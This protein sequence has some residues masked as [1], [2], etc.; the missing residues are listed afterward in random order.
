MLVYAH[1]LKNGGHFW[2]GLIYWACRLGRPGSLGRKKSP[3]LRQFQKLADPKNSACP[4]IQEFPWYNQNSFHKRSK[5]RSCLFEEIEEE[6]RKAWRLSLVR[7]KYVVWLKS[8]IYCLWSFRLDFRLGQTVCHEQ[9][10]WFYNLLVDK[11]T[12]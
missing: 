8:K 10:F 1:L 7:K 9:G 12:I 11:S 5:K 2:N 4:F 3:I 6:N